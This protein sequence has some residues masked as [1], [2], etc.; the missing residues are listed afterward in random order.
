MSD[1]SAIQIPVQTGILSDL[2]LGLKPSAP[3]SRS[4]RISIAPMNKAVFVGQDTII[5]EAPVSRKGTWL[6]QSQSYLKFTVQVQ[7]T[8]QAQ[9]GGSGV[10]LDNTAYSFF[11]RL[12]VFNSS[13]QLETINNY[14]DLCNILLDTS[15]SQSDKAGLSTLIGSNYTP[16]VVQNGATYAQYG[17]NSVLSSAGD[18]SGMSLATNTTAAI[19]LP[20]KT[21]G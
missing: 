11:S 3:K 20:Q 10:Y 4:Y 12:D 5:I 6:D 13:N 9:Q 21:V 17:L 2:L 16:V 8:A 18:R 1:P 14:G 7:T 19:S 15:L